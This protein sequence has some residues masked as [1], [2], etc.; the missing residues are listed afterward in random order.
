[1]MRKRVFISWICTVAA[2]VA[3]TG[4]VFAQTGDDRPTAAPSQDYCIT[5]MS[6]FPNDEAVQRYQFFQ[7]SKKMA[8]GATPDFNAA[9]KHFGDGSVDPETPVI[10]VIDA[11][12]NPVIRQAAPELVVAYMG[13]LIDFARRCEIF[14]DGQ[15][16]ALAAFNPDL[17]LDDIV[18]AEDALY[19]R[20]IL[21][22]S[23]MRL[24]ADKDPRYSAAVNRY[25][26][27]LVT[28]RDNIEFQAYA[29]EIGE[30][31]ALYMTDL[32]GRLA[33]S[34]DIINSEINRETLGDAVQLSDDMN[35][36]AKEQHQ[37]RT[38]ETLLRIL[39]RY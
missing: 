24:D 13:H 36:G 39:N 9:M 2:S 25:A 7:L 23:L 37:R 22:D 26:T 29:S 10:D 21:S 34:N 35:K 28:M 18:I 20:Q 27:S 11:I 32:D 38:V 19:L 3:L 15:V 6:A 30:I 17:A 4:P 31:E 14:V 12:A 16:N 1:M 5:V 8:V 33:R